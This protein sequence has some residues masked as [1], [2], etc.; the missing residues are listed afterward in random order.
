ME[1]VAL[2]LGLVTA[3]ATSSFEAMDAAVKHIHAPPLS[4]HTPLRDIA[5][6]RTWNRGALEHILMTPVRAC[7]TLVASLLLLGG[8]ATRPINPPIA[9]Y[10][11]RTDHQFE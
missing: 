3:S 4:R 2:V 6:A 1:V 10:D 8:C 7:L 9:H 11:P 5:I